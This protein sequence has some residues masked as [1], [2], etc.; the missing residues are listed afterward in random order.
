MVEY[1]RQYGLS[2]E[3]LA[4]YET[5]YRPDLLKGEVALVSGAATGIGRGI[6]TL[7]ARL[8]ADVMICGRNAE[9]LVEAAGFLSQFG[10]RVVAQPANIREPESVET[11]IARTFDEFGRLDHLINNAGGQFAANAVDISTKGWQAVVDTNLNGTW[12]MTQAAARRWIDSGASGSIITITALIERGINQM[13]HTI[14][15]RAGAIYLARTLALEWAPYNIRVNT[16]APGVV[17]SSGFNNYREDHLAHFFTAGPMRRPG[18]V[19]DIAEA[20]VYLGAPSG[21]YITGQTLIVAG[22]HDIHGDLWP[23]GIPDH[24]K[25]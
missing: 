2:D 6:A 13:A 14:A 4:S 19:M 8:G 12:Y 1:T 7:F 25:T 11:L 24:F 23:A 15:S 16:V 3:Q 18:N 22:G 20:C 5:V 21:N 17:A 10:T 9:R